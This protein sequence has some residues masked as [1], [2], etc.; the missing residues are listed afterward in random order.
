[1]ILKELSVTY[2][3]QRDN[4]ISPLYSCFPT[5]MAMLIDW[6][7]QLKGEIPEQI[8]VPG[9][10]QIEDWLNQ[11]LAGPETKTW[12][13]RYKMANLIGKYHPRE[14]YKVEA[15]V[16][17]SLVKSLGFQLIHK[18]VDYEEIT[19]SIEKNFPVVLGGNFKSS[20]RVGAHV[21]CVVGYCISSIRTLIVHD[22]YGN[23]KEGYPQH[24]GL[25]MYDADGRAVRYP[26]NY[27][28]NGKGINAIVVEEL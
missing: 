27:F 12:M 11:V 22:P 26:L 21:V 19:Q 7:L 9:G 6:L 13:V 28:R 8:G 25:T 5:S 16:G 20:S 23:A 4:K 2:F 10:T 17:S 3:S 18:V 1:M 14:L 24:A 15:Y